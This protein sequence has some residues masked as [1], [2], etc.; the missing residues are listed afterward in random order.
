[1]D[2]CLVEQMVM[3]EPKGMEGWRM[4]RIEY[5]GHAENCIIEGVLWLPQDVNYERVED[6]LNNL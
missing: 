1:M 3:R 2:I 6:Y 4:Y 5:G